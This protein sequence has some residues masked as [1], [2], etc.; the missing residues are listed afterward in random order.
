MAM[1]VGLHK[2]QDGADKDIG[3]CCLCCVAASIHMSKPVHIVRETP[4]TKSLNT[5]MRDK[6]ASRQTF[7]NASNRLYTVP[8]DG[9]HHGL[10]GDSHNVC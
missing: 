10:L 8:N 6:N 4:L 7:V 3:L 2:Q 1:P 5:L 9:T